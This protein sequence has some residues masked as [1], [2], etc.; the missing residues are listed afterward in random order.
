[1]DEVL[2]HAAGDRR[3]ASCA[4]GV[5]DRAM[6]PDGGYDEGPPGDAKLTATSTAKGTN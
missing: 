6:A 5:A 4:T 3:S 1:M 2:A